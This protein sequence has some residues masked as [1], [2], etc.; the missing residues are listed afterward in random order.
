VVMLNIKEFFFMIID[1]L[2]CY[3]NLRIFISFK[4]IKYTTLFFVFICYARSHRSVVRLCC[5]YSFLSAVKK[6]RL[7]YTTRCHV[8]IHF[9]SSN[10]KVRS[11]QILLSFFLKLSFK[12]FLAY[13]LNLLL[14]NIRSSV[15]STSFNLNMGFTHSL[16]ENFN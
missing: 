15:H 3:G 13:C 8:V 1:I 16:F 14:D 12:F 11:F 7:V 4:T 6:I 10:C 2:S 9:K 5:N